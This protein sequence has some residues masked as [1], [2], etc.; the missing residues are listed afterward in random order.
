ML[1]VFKWQHLW[2]R[3]LKL[4]PSIDP[5]WWRNRLCRLCQWNGRLAVQRIIFFPNSPQGARKCPLWFHNS[6]LPTFSPGTLVVLI[7]LEFKVKSEKEIVQILIGDLF[8]GCLFVKGWGEIY[9]FTG[10]VLE[11]ESL[12]TSARSSARFHPSDLEII[13]RWVCVCREFCTMYTFKDGNIATGFVEVL[14]TSIRAGFNFPSFWSTPW[15]CKP[16]GIWAQR[17]WLF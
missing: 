15:T 10:V 12:P 3:T 2:R 14:L 9:Q 16:I 7:L 4:Q 5:M 8:S 11:Q 1:S 6:S 13:Y 17:G